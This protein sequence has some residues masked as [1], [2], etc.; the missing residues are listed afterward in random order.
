MMKIKYLVLGVAGAALITVGLF[1]CSNEET[2]NSQHEESQTMTSKSS[3]FER[4][5]IATIVG[6]TAVPLYDET[7][8]TTALL[9][10]DV[11]AEVESIDLD[12]L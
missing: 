8:L 12:Y 11:F 9:A 6:S 3:V 2:N 1:S 4:E 5:A 10:E 7:T